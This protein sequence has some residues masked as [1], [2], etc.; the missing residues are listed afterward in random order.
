MPSFRSP[1][2]AFCFVALAV[3]ACS[4]HSKGPETSPETS[5]IAETLKQAQAQFAL[6]RFK[7]A[8]ELFSNAYDKY[9]HPPGLRR[10]YIKM[11]EEIKSTADSAYQSGE[12]AKAGIDYNILLESGITT[13]DFAGSLPFD[14]NYLD[15][16]IKACSKV[17]M[18]NGLMKYREERLEEAIAIWK[19][20]LFFDPDNRN[21]KNAFETATAQLQQLKN[22]K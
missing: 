22:I 17:L 7:H 11:G 10:S 16:Q 18:E 2:L 5:S 4:L 19:K 21:I 15:S 1:H 9:H 6:G 3:V 14:D 20:A 12:V 13:Q 8:L